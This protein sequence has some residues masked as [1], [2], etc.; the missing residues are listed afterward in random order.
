MSLSEP[1]TQQHLVTYNVG[2]QVFVPI[3]IRRWRRALL[4]GGNRSTLELHIR[5]LFSLATSTFH[6]VCNNL[7]SWG[8]ALVLN[9]KL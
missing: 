7:R 3:E 9:S 2:I 4:A 5:L 1:Y 8:C 6:L